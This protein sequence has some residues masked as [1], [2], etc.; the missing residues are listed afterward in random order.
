[1]AFNGLLY[2]VPFK[3]QSSTVTHHT[4]NSSHK[5]YCLSVALILS[6]N[7]HTALVSLPVRVHY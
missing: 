3:F 7:S 2:A 4:F 6:I 1:M 5:T